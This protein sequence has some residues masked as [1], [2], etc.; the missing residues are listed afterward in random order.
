MFYGNEICSYMS[1]SFISLDFKEVVTVYKTIQKHFFS[2]LS[3]EGWQLK[4]LH[5]EQQ[6]TPALKHVL[7]REVSLGMSKGFC[8][9]P[10][11]LGGDDFEQFSSY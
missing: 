7:F 10:F 4:P 1:K 8:F 2:L 6:F 5:S 3:L 11:T 9:S